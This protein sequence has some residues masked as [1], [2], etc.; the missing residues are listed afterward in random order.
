MNTAAPGAP[1]AG[2]ATPPGGPRLPAPLPSDPRALRRMFSDAFLIDVAL[3]IFRVDAEIASFA[4]LAVAAKTPAELDMCTS[5]QNQI[6]D[7]RGR[8]VAQCMA[9]YGSC[10]A[11]VDTSACVKMRTFL[12]SVQRDPACQ[13]RRELDFLFLEPGAQAPAQE[14]APPA[15][16]ARARAARA[17][18]RRPVGRF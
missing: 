9:L 3:F 11:L 12:R 16:A 5:A 18:A 10:Q 15:M 8:Y 17:R 4:S 14:P 2:A 6:A 13:L 7:A 1:P